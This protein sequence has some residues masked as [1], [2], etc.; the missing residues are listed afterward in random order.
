M[1]NPFAK[2]RFR[3]VIT[4]SPLLNPPDSI[5]QES[6]LLGIAQIGL[7]LAGFIGLFSVFRASGSWTCKD[8]GALRMLLDHAL[9]LVAF[10][11]LPIMGVHIV[12]NRKILWQAASLLMSLFLAL[13]LGYNISTGYFGECERGPTKLFVYLFVPVTGF[14]CVSTFR[15]FLYGIPA[16]FFRAVYWT[17]FNVGIQFY[18]LLLRIMTELSNAGSSP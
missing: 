17:L 13:E 5:P 2:V 14:F 10:A 1:R 3:G 11:I 7:G 6:Q 8:L 4:R 9:G 18:L 15:N 16:R 12:G